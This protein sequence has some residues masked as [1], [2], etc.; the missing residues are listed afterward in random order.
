[1]TM[2][3]PSFPRLRGTSRL[4]PAEA[5]TPDVR[6]IVVVNV[7]DLARQTSKLVDDVQQSGTAV[8]I[9]RHG[10]PVA[11]LTPV[12]KEDLEH[13]T[14]ANAPR[15]TELESN[16]TQPAGDQ[17]GSHDKDERSTA[18]APRDL[19]GAD[20]SVDP[21]V[22]PKSPVEG[23]PPSFVSRLWSRARRIGPSPP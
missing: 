23:A 13:F 22:D 16:P 17:G 7:R 20:N 2:K 21:V 6:S 19:V 15:L 9:T 5:K 10:V 4:S 12:D 11:T 14:R 1:M 3:G 8:L 18:E